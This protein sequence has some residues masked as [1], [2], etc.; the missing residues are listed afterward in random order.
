MVARFDGLI[1]AVET[2]VAGDREGEEGGVGGGGYRQ[3]LGALI[4][5]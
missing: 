3:V 1:T 4:S 2:G 5:S